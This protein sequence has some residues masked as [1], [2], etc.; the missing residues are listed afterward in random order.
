MVCGPEIAKLLDQFQSNFSVQ[1]GAKP[2]FHHEEGVAAQKTF[3]KQALSLIE[4]ISKF[5]NPF[6]D[7][8]PEL[9]ILNSRDCAD[10]AVITT[11]RSIEAIGTA[12][13]Q[14]TT[15]MS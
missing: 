10:D 8:C 5:G 13:F 4:T 3:K 14:N 2:H 11:V 9:L 7:D 15:R 12:K 1:E 6:L